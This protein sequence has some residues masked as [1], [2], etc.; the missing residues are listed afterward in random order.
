MI[1]HHWKSV[2]IGLLG[3]TLAGVLLVLAKSI[4][5][6]ASSDRTIS[7]FDFPQDVPLAGW[8][9][10]E[11]VPLTPSEDALFLSARNYEYFQNSLSLDINI[12]YVMVGDASGMQGFIEQYGY[13]NWIVNQVEMQQNEN[14]GFYGF[15][16]TEERVN[17]G[18][19][20]HPFPGTTLTFDQF[21]NHYNSNAFQ[22]NRIIPWLV[23]MAPL[24]DTRCL[25]TTLSISIE[26]GQSPEAVYPVLEQAWFSWY[27]W[28]QPRFP[29]P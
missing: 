24:R 1:T 3:T 29:K 18:G 5:Y 9:S 16:Q 17:L 4:F 23:G 14:I 15:W 19:C 7:A 25:W 22:L 6:P 12:Y 8:Q 10:V 11:S 28:W 2:R 26:A 20:I 13:G 27:K 21:G